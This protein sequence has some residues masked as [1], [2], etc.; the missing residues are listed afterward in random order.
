MGAV[1]G[2]GTALKGGGGS[3]DDVFIDFFQQVE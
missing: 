2:V 1:A 3:D